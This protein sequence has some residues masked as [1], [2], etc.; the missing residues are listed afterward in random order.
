MFTRQ[1]GFSLIELLI[2]MTVSMVLLS[3]LVYIFTSFIRL[4]TDM[5]KMIRLNQDLRGIMSIMI[6]DIRRAGYWSQARL[7]VGSNIPNRFSTVSVI[8]GDCILYSYDEQKNNSTGI[9]ESD[10]YA[11]FKLDQSSIMIKTSAGNCL[12]KNCNN[13]NAGFWW[14]LNDNNVV[15]I[16]KLHFR[17]VNNSF[18]FMQGTMQLNVRR[19]DIMLGGA[20]VHAPDIT[21]TL[22]DS[23]YIP[24]NE[25]IPIM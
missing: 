10:D 11:G 5:V 12:V 25:I 15:H 23:V 2:A 17:H 8:N 18:P 6:N 21:Y 7:A 16:T 14:K 19:I 24:N 1:N 4:N 22:Q 13:C 3:G 9:P 20:L